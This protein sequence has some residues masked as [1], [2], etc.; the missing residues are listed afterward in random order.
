M[1]KLAE[2]KQGQILSLLGLKFLDLAR[3]GKEL[4]ALG[5]LVWLV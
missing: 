5:P 3:F 4:P 1:Y 2:H